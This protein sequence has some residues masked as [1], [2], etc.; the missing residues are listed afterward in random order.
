MNR[1]GNEKRKKKKSALMRIV[2]CLKFSFVI[3]SLML[4]VV[5]IYFLFSF[6]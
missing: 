6:V 5:I 2:A 3:G 4:F 1:K